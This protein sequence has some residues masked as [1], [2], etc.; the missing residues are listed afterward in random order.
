MKKNRKLRL[1]KRPSRLYLT[2]FPSTD[3]FFNVF[4]CT[5]LQ[6]IQLYDF[7]SP[8]NTKCSKNFDLTRNFFDTQKFLLHCIMKIKFTHNFPLAKHDFV[9]SFALNCTQ[10]KL[11]NFEK[12]SKNTYLEATFSTI[13]YRFALSWFAYWWPPLKIV[14]KHLF[15]WFC[16]RNI[17][18]TKKQVFS[19]KFFSTQNFLLYTIMKIMFCHS[20][21]LFKR[22]SA[23]SFA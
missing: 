17:E 20:F 6:R 2:A 3:L 22:D 19:L 5:L 18:K 21:S 8:T 14:A 15:M 1:W 13:S 4:R 9:F 16:L 23:V 11:S 10:H 7:Y 12:N